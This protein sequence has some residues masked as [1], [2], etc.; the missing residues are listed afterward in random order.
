MS[1]LKRNIKYLTGKALI[2][3]EERIEQSIR[4][5]DVISFD[6]FDTLIKR[7]VQEPTDIH[8]LVS[9]EFYKE[10]GIR[11]SDY[12]K[13]RIEAEHSARMKS[14]KE[15]VTL[16]E[17]YD[18]FEQEL[19]LYREEIEKIE[20]QTEIHL[21]C[22]NTEML[23]LY[24]RVL[25]SGKTVI[26]TSDMYL[27]E[28]C[29]KAMLTKC[30][31]V[32]YEK[33]YLS[34]SYLRSKAKASLFQIVQKEYEEKKILHIG[35]DIKADY[36]MAKKVGI[37]AILIDQRK[38]KLRYW[39]KRERLFGEAAPV[40]GRLRAFLANHVPEEYNDATI[41]GHEIL[42]PLLLGFCSY[43]HEK[44]HQDH[45]EKLFFLSREGKI[46]MDAYNILY[47]GETIPISYLYVSR[48]ALVV[49]LLSDAKNFDDI[50]NGIKCFL[51][52]SRLKTI[53]KVCLLDE[54]VYRKRLKAI[55]LDENQDI[56]HL[57]E[58]Q[59]SQLYFFIYEEN[60]EYFCQQRNYV[61]QYLEENG[62][63]GNVGVVDVGWEGTMQIRLKKLVTDSNTT[64]HGYYYGI[65]NFERDE[66]YKDIVRS[67]FLFEKNRNRRL[68]L[69]SRW[70]ACIFEFLFLN[71][72]GSVRNYGMKDGHIE[73]QLNDAEYAE[74]EKIFIQTM[75]NTAL[76]T[77]KKIRV[78]SWLSIDSREMLIILKR[79]YSDFAGYPSTKTVHMF[80]KFSVLNG[81][82]QKMLP[83]RSLFWYLLHPRRLQHDFGIN[84]SK[85]LFLK[86][87]FKI[88]LPYF[89]I[90]YAIEMIGIQSK[91]KKEL[92]KK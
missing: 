75:Q 38:D 86:K 56:Y 40:Y 18:A 41:L 25:Q 21:C 20:I 32:G 83:N 47:P 59:K 60:K 8:D 35:D 29:I 7:N 10:K 44:V 51:I 85:I 66:A 48:Q 16:E 22:P 70:S 92:Y 13:K 71:E 19:A 53:Q 57:S 77:L 12:K 46:I 37:N 9:Q 79:V 49:P 76:N 24:H 90:L 58:E 17:I 67:G 62:F 69:M 82:V 3:N 39:K 45:L 50:V 4:N 1:S 87:I 43:L 36:I 84:C 31:Y 61:E 89:D 26:I 52:D 5:A 80:D 63:S 73:A 78:A 27:P 54:N 74:S 30:G 72:N 11:L 65:R 34:S 88:P 6:I 15:E 64:I 23:K 33:L 81:S 68:D 2:T 55:Q 91:F 42:A 14:D 28:E